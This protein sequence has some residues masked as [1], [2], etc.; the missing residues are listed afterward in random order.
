[1]VKELVSADCVNDLTY[2][3]VLRFK[4]GRKIVISD[5]CVVETSKLAKFA[6]R[7]VSYEDFSKIYHEISEKI[8]CNL[9]I[10]SKHIVAYHSLFYFN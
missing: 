2:V 7:S 1:M 6:T 4:G 9:E 3:G 10:N 5:Y 8:G